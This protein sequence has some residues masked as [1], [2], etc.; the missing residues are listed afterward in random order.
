MTG[1]GQDLLHPF[2]ITENGESYVFKLRDGSW[3]VLRCVIRSVD[4]SLTVGPKT[5]SADQL[6]TVEVG[7]DT[8][9]G[10]YSAVNF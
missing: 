3:L 4:L 2:A 8:R 7:H 6:Q 10:D 9:S 1:Y 5:F